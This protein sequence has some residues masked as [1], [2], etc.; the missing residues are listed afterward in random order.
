M[1]LLVAIAWLNFSFSMCCSDLTMEM[2]R[3]RLIGPQSHSVL[4]ETLEAA[5]DCDVSIELSKSESL[6]EIL[7][8][9]KN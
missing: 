8:F 1:V 4:T 5:T 9:T 6:I 2:V 3:Y 7:H